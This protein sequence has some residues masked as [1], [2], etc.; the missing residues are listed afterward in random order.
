MSRLRNFKEA[1]SCGGVATLGI[2]RRE[3]YDGNADGFVDVGRLAL[4][5]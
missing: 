3:E 4:E 2:F 5:D 1:G